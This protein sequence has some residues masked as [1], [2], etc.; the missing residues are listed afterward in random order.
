MVLCALALINYLAEVAIATIS[1]LGRGRN[2][3]I[4]QQGCL[5]FS[6]LLRHKDPK[7]VIFLQYLAG[8]AMVESIKRIP[9]LSVSGFPF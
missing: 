8:L 6:F 5:M 1:R 7:S 2:S 3:W 9:G 4:S